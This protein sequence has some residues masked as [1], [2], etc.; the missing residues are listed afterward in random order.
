MIP[1]LSLDAMRGPIAQQLPLA[2]KNELVHAAGTAVALTARR[3]IGGCYGARVAVIAG[4][5]LNGADG[6]VAARG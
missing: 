2:A 1:I 3:M 6:R 4:P 5:G